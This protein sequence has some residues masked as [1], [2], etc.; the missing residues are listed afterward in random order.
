MQFK[1]GAGV[2]TSD[3]KHVGSIDRVVMDPNT[4]EVSHLVIREGILF[5][6]DKVIPVS[7]I[8]STTPDRVE[9]SQPEREMGQYPMFEE[10]QFVTDGVNTDRLPDGTKVGQDSTA[11][12]VRPAD[13]AMPLYW[14]PPVGMAWWTAGV[15][16]DLAETGQATRVT[17]NIPQESVPLREGANVITADGQHVGDVEQVLTNPGDARATHIV[18]S[19]GLLLKSRRVIPSYWISK[20][21]EGELRLSVDA[22][23]IDRL[24]E[25]QPQA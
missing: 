10:S 2:Y 24:P 19:Q 9:L 18:I 11:S 23:F 13:M 5:T 3:G 14:Y 22:A 21:D 7:L 17:R 6:E 20:I 15:Y 12:D 1:A 8:R 4:K 25:Y 16:P